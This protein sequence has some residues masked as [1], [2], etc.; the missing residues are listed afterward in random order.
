MKTETMPAKTAMPGM[1]AMAGGMMM[2]GMNM[3]MPGMNMGMGMPSMGM[4]APMAMVAKC[5]M[6]MQMIDSGMKMMLET[7]QA[8]AA[9]ALTG[10]CDMM[11]GGMMTMTMMM[12]GM[13]MMTMNMGLMGPCRYTKMALGAS[14]E[15]RM[16]DKNMMAMM[17]SGMDMMTKMLES[18]MTCMIMMNGMPIAFCG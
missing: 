5:R 8:D 11:Q 2:P 10:A 18:G 7:D 14:F 15:L 9:A 17:K 4:G 12:N 13:A 6:S 3:G 1:M 16:A